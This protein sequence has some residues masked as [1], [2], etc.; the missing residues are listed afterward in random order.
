MNYKNKY[1][2]FGILLAI[3]LLIPFSGK[4]QGTQQAQKLLDAVAEKVSSYE[5]IEIDFTWNLVNQKEQ[6]DQKTQGSVMLSGERYRLSMMGMTRVFDG[7]KLYTIAPD[8]FEITVSNLDPEEDKNVTP[9]KLL[10]FYKEGYT[11]SW[12]IRQRVGGRNIQYVKLYPIDTE[13][14][15]KHM[16]LGIDTASKHIY[17]LIQ[18]DAQ[19]T[20][21][22]LTVKSLRPNQKL[23]AD[24][25]A[26]DLTEYQNQGYYINTLYWAGENS[27]SLYIDQFSQDLF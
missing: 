10:T 14:E 1:Q 20:Q 12:D 25:F 17:K 21:F 7:N 5:D 6:V 24:T 22:I 15:I 2:R 8:D 23:P 13:A 26:V 27:G 16:L 3:G 4:G 11:Y 9:S 18:T 19:G